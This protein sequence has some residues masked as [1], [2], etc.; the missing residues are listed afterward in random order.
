[1]IKKV[2][3]AKSYKFIKANTKAV[4]IGIGFANADTIAVWEIV[5]RKIVNV[6]LNYSKTKSYQILKR[7]PLLFIFL[8]QFSGL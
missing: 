7:I 1:M 6:S 4:S 2:L 5:K 3:L 8:H